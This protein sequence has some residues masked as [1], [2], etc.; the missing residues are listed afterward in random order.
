MHS[1]Q[2]GRGVSA[3]V[4]EVHGRAGWC[5]SAARL[6][7]CRGWVRSGLMWSLRLSVHDHAACPVLLS[8]RGC[9]R[10]RGVLR[11]S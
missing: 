3:G 8:N 7:T 2:R 11:V 1:A 4:G 6:V 9:C 10:R 5:S